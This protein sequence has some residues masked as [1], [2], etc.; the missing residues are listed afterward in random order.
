MGGSV[1][2]DSSDRDGTTENSEGDPL[3]PAERPGHISF[4]QASGLMTCC[5]F[6]RVFL[7]SRV[8]DENLLSGSGQDQRYTN[9]TEGSG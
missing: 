2:K 8:R 6:R 4:V 7:T 5:L 9:A 1:L 3:R